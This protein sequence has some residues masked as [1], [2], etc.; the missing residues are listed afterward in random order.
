MT[1]MVPCGHLHAVHPR[2]D[3]TL[4][5][6]LGD[7][8]AFLD[9]AD[10]LVLLAADD[11]QVVFRQLPPLLLHLAGQ[12]LPVAFDAIPIHDSLLSRV[13]KCFIPMPQQRRARA[14][15]CAPETLCA[16]RIDCPHRGV[17]VSK[18]TAPRE[19]STR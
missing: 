17:S 16:A 7:A 14:R 11:G 1:W 12:L 15:S 9:A 4:R 19:P 10:E 13:Q 3:L 6:V 18:F 2:I 5:L 8:I